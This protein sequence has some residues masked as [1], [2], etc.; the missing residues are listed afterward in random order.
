MKAGPLR[1][2]WTV[3]QPDPEYLNKVISGVADRTANKPVAQ[4]ERAVQGLMAVYQRGV[5]PA[6]FRLL[7]SPLVAWIW[8]GGLIVFAGGLIA[9]WPAPEAAR[10]RARA[11]YAARVAQDL[12]RA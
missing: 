1:D 4:Q 12:D 6:Q 8:I 2:V 9:L 10:G 3:I 7:V 5:I 11:G